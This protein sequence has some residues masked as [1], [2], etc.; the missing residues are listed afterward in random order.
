MYDISLGML[1]AKIGGPLDLL[2]AKASC[3]LKIIPAR[4]IQA[5]V[6]ERLFSDER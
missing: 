4:S 1:H 5:S 3:P 6:A 2:D